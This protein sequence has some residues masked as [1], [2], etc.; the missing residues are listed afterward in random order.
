MFYYSTPVKGVEDNEPIDVSQRGRLRKRRIIPNNVEDQFGSKKIR[1][2]LKTEETQTAAEP[3]IVQHSKTELVDYA[4]IIRHLQ[5]RQG[6]KP[7]LIRSSRGGRTVL[8]SVMPI[9]QGGAEGETT[10]VELTGSIA[11]PVL[12]NSQLHQQHMDT[13]D[14]VRVCQHPTIR[15]L[16]STSLSSSSSK[17]ILQLHPNLHSTVGPNTGAITGMNMYMPFGIWK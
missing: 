16:L 15:T 13:P 2:A 5:N 7:L 4:D 8:T 1:P 11:S 17:P 9:A 10:T 6:G 14:S 3:V 12:T